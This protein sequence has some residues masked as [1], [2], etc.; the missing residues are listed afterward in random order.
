MRP[1]SLVS[2]LLTAVVATAACE[3]TVGHPVA[4]PLDP[5]RSRAQIVAIDAVV[6]EDTPLTE[7]GRV[8]MADAF[9]ELATVATADAT[10]TVAVALGGELRTLSSAVSRMRAGTR[11]A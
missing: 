1:V 11:V 7:D 8:I 4:R 3:T 10:N 5:E 2:I 9:A 6:F